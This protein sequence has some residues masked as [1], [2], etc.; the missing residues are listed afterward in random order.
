MKRV[1]L[2]VLVERRPPRQIDRRVV[3]RG[4]AA[5][6]LATLAG[7]GTDVRQPTDELGDESGDGTTGG[8]TTGGGSTGGGST[9]GSSGGGSTGGGSTGGGATSDPGFSTCG[10]ELCIDLA[11][12]ANAALRDVDGARVISTTDRK[13]LIVRTDET[14]FVA[15]SAICT[16]A[17]CTVRYAAGSRDVVCPCHG[18][19]FEL[20]GTVTNGPAL[21]PLDVF[22][23]TYD[24][25]TGIVK[26]AL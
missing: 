22:P 9:G 7:C 18:S 2:P 15:L 20:D 3:L 10:G 26:I 4:M 13:F 21:E 5:T 23:A 11:A 19:T 16:H 8:G 17:G 12:D 14:T 25:A 24:A 6:L 1:T